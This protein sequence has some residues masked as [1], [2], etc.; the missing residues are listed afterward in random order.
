MTSSS[1]DWVLARNR[2]STDAVEACCERPERLAEEVVA[3]PTRVGG[4]MLRLECLAEEV[5][6]PPTQGRWSRST[7]FSV[8]D[9]NTP[10]VII[11]RRR[12][13]WFRFTSLPSYTPYDKERTP[14]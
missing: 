12:L 10:S 5:V 8:L 14:L 13:S 9:C 3:P 1:R 6:A 7:R 11:Q 4:G 2:S